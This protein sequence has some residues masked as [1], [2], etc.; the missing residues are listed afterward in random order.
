MGIQ[1]DGTYLIEGGETV[2]AAAEAFGHSGEW[3]ELTNAN[4]DVLL[5]GT[6]KPPMGVGE[7]LL[8]VAVLLVRPGMVLVQ[9][10]SWLPPP[11][12]PPARSTSKATP[13]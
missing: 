6:D 12:P 2:A 9:P 3:P 4:L 11:P 7:G 5:E 10:T 1:I 13:L 8:S